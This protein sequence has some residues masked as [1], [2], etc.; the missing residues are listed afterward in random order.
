MNLKIQVLKGDSFQSDS[1]NFHLA[2][3]KAIS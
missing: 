3:V 1:I 2:R